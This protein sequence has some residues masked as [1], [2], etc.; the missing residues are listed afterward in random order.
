MCMVAV[1]GYSVGE[2][3]SD[4]H[5]EFLAGQL[6]YRL[7]TITGRAT[8]Y[9]DRLGILVPDCN[10]VDV[11][12]YREDIRNSQEKKARFSRI[13]SMLAKSELFDAPGSHEG[14]PFYK[15]TNYLSMVF[16]ESGWNAQTV[17]EGLDELF[18]L[19]GEPNV[20]NRGPRKLT[21]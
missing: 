7:Q 12:K 3:L 8:E 14:Y 6:R 11:W 4:F 10:E 20:T 9:K 13:Y 2:K 19:R 5:L 17:K 15:S 16:C 18:K 1:I 21:I